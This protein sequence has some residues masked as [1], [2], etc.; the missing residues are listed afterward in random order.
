MKKLY[1]QEIE[2]NGQELQQPGPDKYNLPLSF[3]KK[4][5]HYSLREAVSRKES[6]LFIM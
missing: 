3:G 4:G 6:K 1:I 2:K 5:L